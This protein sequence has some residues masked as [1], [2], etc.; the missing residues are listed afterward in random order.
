MM[1][2]KNSPTLMAELNAFV[3]RYPEGSLQRNVLT[4]KYLKSVKYAKGA[5]GKEDLARFRQTVDF[6]R[7]YSAEYKLDYLLIGNRKVK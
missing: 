3:D 4:Q 7:K 2:R 6:I 5:T 1:V